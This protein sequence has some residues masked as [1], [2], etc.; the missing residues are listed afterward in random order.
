M[1]PGVFP[2]SWNIDGLGER[3][4]EN[5][6]KGC[7]INQQWM[8]RFWVSSVKKKHHAP[9]LDRV[10]PPKGTEWVLA[11]FSSKELMVKGNA[12]LRERSNTNHPWGVP[13]SCRTAPHSA[14][15][16]HFCV[17]T[18]NT[19]TP[20]NNPGLSHLWHCPVE[21]RWSGLASELATAGV[22][23]LFSKLSLTYQRG[24]EE[25]LR[26]HLVSSK[27]KTNFKLWLRLRMVC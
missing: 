15:H 5:S 12:P 20:P 26:T 24:E 23:I 21:V 25:R 19:E 17:Q 11:L 6:G 14:P 1:Q 16:I 13:R 8:S 18:Q 22:N 2:G 10:V 3:G 7:K 9:A 27:R 4:E